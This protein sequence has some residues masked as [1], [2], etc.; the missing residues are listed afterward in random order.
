MYEDYLDS[1]NE[2]KTRIVS[3]NETQ[4]DSGINEYFV[5]EVAVLQQKRA[6]I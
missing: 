2:S 3:Y 4:R 1:I 5:K 6:Q